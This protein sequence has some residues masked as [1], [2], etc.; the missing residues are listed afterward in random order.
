MNN[1]I[2]A[3]LKLIFNAEDIES[4]IRMTAEII[5]NCQ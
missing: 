1:T 2:L 3:I 4:A 5:E